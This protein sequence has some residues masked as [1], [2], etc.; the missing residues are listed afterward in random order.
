M[1]VRPA[2]MFMYFS[3][4]SF[5]RVLAPRANIPPESGVNRVIDLDEFS[6]AFVDLSLT[7]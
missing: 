1:L 6:Y 3:D 4:S 2:A 5:S 7:L